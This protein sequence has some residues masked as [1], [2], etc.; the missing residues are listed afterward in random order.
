V[1]ISHDDLIDV[2]ARRYRRGT[3]LQYASEIKTLAFR[4]AARSTSI[5]EV[6]VAELREYVLRLESNAMRKRFLCAAHGFFGWARRSRRRRTDPSE[7]L[8]FK[9]L[10]IEPSPPRV[11]LTFLEK[12]GLDRRRAKKLTWTD[13]IAISGT[14]AEVRGRVHVD[15]VGARAIRAYLHDTLRGRRM[16]ALLDDPSPAV[17]ATAARR[18]RDGARRKPKSPRAGAAQSKGS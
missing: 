2:W 7:S 3:V 5:F 8:R 13:L 10:R 4:L 6:E 1:V 15:D 18:A 16:L 17:S 11:L 12:S 9:D 14:P